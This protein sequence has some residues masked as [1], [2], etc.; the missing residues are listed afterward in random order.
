MERKLI[1]LGS[2]PSVSVGTRS[3]Y[4][5]QNGIRTQVFCHVSRFLL[6]KTTPQF[7]IYF[8]RKRTC[9]KRN[10]GAFFLLFWR[11]EL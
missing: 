10:Y 6:L 9:S 4:S 11:R 2:Y 3:N 8:L 7:R 5:Y 1:R